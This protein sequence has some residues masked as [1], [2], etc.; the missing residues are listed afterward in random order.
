M[1]KFDPILICPALFLICRKVYKERDI[2]GDAHTLLLVQFEQFVH[3]LYPFNKIPPT[4]EDAFWILAQR[5]VP[6]LSA[7]AQVLLNISASEAACERSF[8]HQKNIQRPVRSS[9]L[10]S[11]CE[12]EM[13][14][15]M[16]LRHFDDG[17]DNNLEVSL[18]EESSQKSCKRQRES[19]S[20]SS[21]LSSSSEQS[22]SQRDCSSSTSFTSSSSFDSTRQR[23]SRNRIVLDSDDDL[24]EITN[25]HGEVIYFP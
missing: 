11:N 23:T 15:Q 3:N 25:E 2:V 6:E 18:Q 14:V 8:S 4:T 12:N 20:S 17:K 1:L 13:M 9:L 16:N 22:L 10:H 24:D 7:V 5:H 21:S 19:E